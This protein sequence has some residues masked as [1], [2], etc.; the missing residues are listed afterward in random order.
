MAIVGSIMLL[1]AMCV[2][3]SGGVHAWLVHPF[4]QDTVMVFGPTLVGIVLVL[5]AIR[6]SR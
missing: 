3:L 6:W 1:P 4:S 5:A 2:L